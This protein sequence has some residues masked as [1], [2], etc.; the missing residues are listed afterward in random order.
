MPQIKLSVI[1]FTGINIIRWEDK[2]HLRLHSHEFKISNKI[3]HALPSHICETEILGS[4]WSTFVAPQNLHDLYW[5]FS[6]LVFL[7][8]HFYDDVIFDFL[9]SLSKI[10]QS[11]QDPESNHLCE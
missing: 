3:P 6:F 11:C 4:W 7:G 5:F 8:I 10:F 1:W 2:A 9:Q